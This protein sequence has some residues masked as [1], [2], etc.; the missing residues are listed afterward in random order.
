MDFDAEKEG[1]RLAVRLITGQNQSCGTFVTPFI[2]GKFR[3][4]PIRNDATR[5]HWTLQYDPQAAGGRGRDEGSIL[6]GLGGL[7]RDGD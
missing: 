3:P 6:G 7:L 4:T 1:A 5:Y 2:P